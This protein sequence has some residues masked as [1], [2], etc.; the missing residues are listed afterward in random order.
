MNPQAAAE[1]SVSFVTLGFLC[2]GFALLYFKVI[3]EPE[4]KRWDRAQ[5]RIDAA[6]KEK[7]DAIDRLREIRKGASGDPS[8]PAVASSPNASESDI[9]S[10]EEYKEINGSTIPVELSRLAKQREGK[11]QRIVVM[12][13][14]AKITVGRTD[15]VTKILFVSFK[16]N[17]YY[18][19]PRRI[20]K[21]TIQK[22]NKTVVIH[23]LEFDILY[24]EAMDAQGNIKWD[25]DL[26]MV[27]ADSTLDQYVTIASSEAGFHFTPTLKRALEIVAF[28]GFLLGLAI[29]GAAHIVPTTLIHWLP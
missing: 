17:L 4:W 23:K 3:K 18:C 11:W 5:R 28:L 8:P 12:R 2:L 25:D 15:D 29:N 20:I 14:Q 26:E 16:K 19:N 21:V 24:A 6:E 10:W 1:V 7:K 27:L 22:R 13:T 9:A